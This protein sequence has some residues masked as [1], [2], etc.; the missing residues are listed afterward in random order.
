MKLA[1][2]R[3]EVRGGVASTIAAS[4]R[5]SRRKGKVSEA[6]G[7]L[8]ETLDMQ[9]RVLRPEHPTTLQTVY[10]M[11]ALRINSGDKAAA[12][13]FFVRAAKGRARALGPTHPAPLQ[14]Q[15]CV[16]MCG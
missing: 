15:K 10:N 8:R 5:R 6:T 16:R 1:V 7:T 12:Q 3:P 4:L 9:R 2:F 11:G 14:A 13:P